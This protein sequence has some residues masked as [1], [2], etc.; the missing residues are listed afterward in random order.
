[1]YE[2]AAILFPLAGAHKAACSVNHGSG[3]L[4]ARGEAKRKLEHKQQRIDEEMATVS[5]TFAG[6]T[7]EGV[8][9]NHKHVPLDECGHVYKDLDSVLAVLEAEG[10]ARVSQ[11][12]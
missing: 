9:G 1:M 12:L 5:R 11:R 3:R 2:G 4:L 6:V 7:I 10:I 8:V